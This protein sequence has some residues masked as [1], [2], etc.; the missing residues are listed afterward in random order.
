MQNILLRFENT[1][2]LKNVKREKKFLQ[3]KMII[4]FVEQ[5]SEFCFVTS[6]TE[7]DFQ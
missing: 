2:T 1:I 4:I 3:Q 5:L 6:K 7:V